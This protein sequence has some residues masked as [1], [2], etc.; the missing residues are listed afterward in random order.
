M[1]YDASAQA[2]FERETLEI[3]FIDDSGPPTG[4]ERGAQSN[5]PGGAEVD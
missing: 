2:Y 5:L 3:L 4:L 1:T